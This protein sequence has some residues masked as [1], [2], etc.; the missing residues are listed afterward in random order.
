MNYHLV[1]IALILL[2][3]ACVVLFGLGQVGAIFL[4]FAVILEAA[5]WV[6]AWR[7]VRR[8]HAGK[9]EAP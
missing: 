7:G 3:G 5:C 1:T 6:V 8:T 9:T 2:A 4:A